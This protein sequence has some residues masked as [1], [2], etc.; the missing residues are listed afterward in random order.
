MER[1]LIVTID[2]TV[3]AQSVPDPEDPARSSAS[4][5]K[6]RPSPMSSATTH[7]SSDRLGW[8]TPTPMSFAP[9]G[10]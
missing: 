7:S 5:P 10:I 1:R 2:G 8:R 4:I 3:V 9:E 6:G